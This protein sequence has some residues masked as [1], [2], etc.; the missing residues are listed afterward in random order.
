MNKEKEIRSIWKIVILHL[1]PG[2]VATLIYVFMLKC[3]VLK[4]YPRLVIFSLA[5]MLAAI[6]TEGYLFYVA[7][8]E[9]GSFNINKILGLKSRLTVKEYI[10]YTLI[11]FLLAGVLMAVFMP[12]TKYMMNSTFSC[13]SW[14]NLLQDMSQFNRFFI[15][16]TIIVNLF[17][18]TVIAVII[19]EHY[20]RGYLLARMKWMGKYGV[21]INV[22]LFAIYHFW[23]PWDTV[24]R[25]FAMLPLYYLVYKKDSL[26]L[27]IFTHVLCNSLDVVNMLMLLK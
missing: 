13:L 9:V 21:L 1:L 3:G 14:Y 25:I 8:K 23:S 20:F 26:K 2:I 16:I 6:P 15:I 11:L 24:A 5:W 7:K 27:A 4:G 18:C 12:V 17:V 22:I 19:E 10:F